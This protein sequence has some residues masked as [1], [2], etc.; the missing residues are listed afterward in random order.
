MIRL[1]RHHIFF[2]GVITAFLFSGIHILNFYMKSDFTQGSIISYDG[3]AARILIKI[4]DKEYIFTAQ[5]DLHLDPAE[6]T[7]VIYD[8]KN[9]ANAS[10]YTFWGF[11]MFYL[12]FII[13]PLILYT[14][15]IYSWFDKFDYVTLHFKTKKISKSKELI[16]KN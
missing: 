8:K 1:N 2:I 6:K 10:V 4:N 14:A 5:S 7:D 12:Y 15:F 13:V 11:Y 3:N 16:R 9:P